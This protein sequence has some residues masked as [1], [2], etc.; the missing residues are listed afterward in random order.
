MPRPFSS[1]QV[2]S[3]EITENVG[4]SPDGDGLPNFCSSTAI[5]AE[6][7]SVSQ[8]TPRFVPESGYLPRADRGVCPAVPSSHGD[9]RCDVRSSLLTLARL[10]SRCR[11]ASASHASHSSHAAAPCCRAK[12]PAAELPLNLPDRGPEHPHG[13]V[14]GSRSEGVTHVS[15]LQASEG[16]GA[17]AFVSGGAILLGYASARRPPTRPNAASLLRQPPAVRFPP[18]AAG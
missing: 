16:I 2:P 6:S 18:A 11:L 7:R 14:F 1:N 4:N 10:L 12:G 8:R 13:V 3:L 17:G 15:G 9:D 5:G